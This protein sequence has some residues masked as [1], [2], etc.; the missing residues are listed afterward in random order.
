MKVKVTRRGYYN[1]KLREPGE[2]LG[3]PNDKLHLFSH[4]WMEPLDP[5]DYKKLPKVKAEMIDNELI[6]VSPERAQEIVDQKQAAL[7]AKDSEGDENENDQTE[8]IDPHEDKVEIS[9]PALGAQ[10]PVSGEGKGKK[11]KKQLTSNNL[12]VI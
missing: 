6:P 7:K 5:E 8:P 1:H 10:E 9:D 11:G 12:D 2:I 3:L 4:N